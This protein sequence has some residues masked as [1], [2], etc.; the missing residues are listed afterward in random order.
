[1]A[2][3]ARTTRGKSSKAKAITKAQMAGE[4]SNKTGLTKAQVNDVF[5]ALSEVVG[6]ELRGGRPVAVPGLVKITLAHKAATPS[7]PGRNPFTG[8]AI[9]IKAKPARKVVRVRALKAL[10]DMA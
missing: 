7:R 9:T 8:E 5:Q 2:S 4:V 1:M 6:E 3:K 10:K